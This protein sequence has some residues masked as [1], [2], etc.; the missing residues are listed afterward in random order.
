MKPNS[1]H[2]IV[3]IFLAALS[4]VVV[5][6]YYSGKRNGER[7]VEAIRKDE[8]MKWQLPEDILEAINGDN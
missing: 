2:Y 3:G 8:K 7:V 4:L 5:A 6:S 1:E